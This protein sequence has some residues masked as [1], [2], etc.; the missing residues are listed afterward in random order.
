MFRT[1]GRSGSRGDPG[2]RPRYLVAKARLRPPNA[3][4]LLRTPSAC[5]GRPNA[6]SGDLTGSREA[7]REL[8]F[9]PTAI[10]VEGLEDREDLLDR[11]LL[12]EGPVDDVKFSPPALSRWRMS[13]INFESWKACWRRPKSPWSSSIQKARPWRC[14]SQR[15]RRKPFQWLRTQLRIAPSPRSCP[16]CSLVIHLWRWASTAP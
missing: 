2:R 12:V 1:G 8:T 7:G 13:S 14:S 4:G 15:A 6:S 9:D 11:V 3:I 10:D 16:A 5:S